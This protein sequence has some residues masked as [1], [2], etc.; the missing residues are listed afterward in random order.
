MTSSEINSYTLSL[1]SRKFFLY[2][3]SKQVGSHQIFV[4]ILLMLQYY[5]VVLLIH[6]YMNGMVRKYCTAMVIMNNFW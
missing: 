2:L 4:D 1:I 5:Y 6:M 3:L